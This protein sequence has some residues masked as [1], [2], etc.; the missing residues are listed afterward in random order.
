MAGVYYAAVDGDPLTSGEGSRVYATKNVGTI[1]DES[2]RPRRMVFIRD[3][4]WCTKC[5][6]TGSIT[7][8]VNIRKGGRMLDLVNGGRDQAVGGDIVL[9]KCADHP[10]IVAA[11]GRKWMI[12]D[13]GQDKVASAARAP[14][15]IF[16]YDQQFTLSDAAGKSLVNTWY[17]V[18]MPSGEL[19]HGITDSAGKTARYRTDGVQR[20]ALYLGHREA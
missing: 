14:A 4:A 9:C 11:Y 3:D 17:T 13:Q 1:E 16:A 6:S 8:G 12:L 10:R 15:Q 18:R 7:Y 20:L 5:N 19:L 2:G